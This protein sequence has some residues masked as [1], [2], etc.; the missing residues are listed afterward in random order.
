MMPVIVPEKEML[1]LDGIAFARMQSAILVFVFQ[2]R[3]ED[4][5]RGEVV[6]NGEAVVG[7]LQVAGVTVPP[8]FPASDEVAMSKMPL[9]P[10]CFAVVLPEDEEGGAASPVRVWAKTAQA[11]VRQKKAVS[12]MRILMCPILSG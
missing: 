6:P 10:D 7:L 8:R 4:F 1:V 5:V 12:A 9:P 11:A 2:R 3:A